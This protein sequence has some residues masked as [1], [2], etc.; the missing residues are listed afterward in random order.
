MNELIVNSKFNQFF[1]Y[2]YYAELLLIILIGLFFI[3]FVYTNDYAYKNKIAHWLSSGT[4]KIII[5]IAFLFLSMNAFNNK[6]TI[7]P[8][9]I[10]NKQMHQ[11]F[12]E[13]H[14]TRCYKILNSIYNSTQKDINKKCNNITISEYYL[15]QI[16][17]SEN[18]ILKDK[19]D[20]KEKFVQDKLLMFKQNDNNLWI[21]QNLKNNNS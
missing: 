7:N 1:T 4:L 13:F 15:L 16:F 19:I 6:E 14:K 10:Q 5:F 9:D 17:L 2:L 11:S 3:S 21:N 20:L 18:L 12:T 8:N